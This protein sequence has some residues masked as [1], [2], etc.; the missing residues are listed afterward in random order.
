[1]MSVFPKIMKEQIIHMVRYR[2]PSGLAWV[3]GRHETVVVEA[4]DQHGEILVAD[5]YICG[6][7]LRCYLLLISHIC[8]IHPAECFQYWTWEKELIYRCL[9]LPVLHFL[10]FLLMA[11]RLIYIIYFEEDG[12]QIDHSVRQE[13]CWSIGLDLCLIGFWH[14]EGICLL[15]SCTKWRSLGFDDDAAIDLSWFIFPAFCYF[16]LCVVIFGLC[17][18]MCLLFHM[19]III[20]IWINY[21]EFCYTLW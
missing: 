1:M 20:I 18:L 12:M 11:W 17:V 8:A 4:G 3:Q 16:V 14:F 6:V 7:W 19:T 2:G 10:V 13:L 21:I 5:L 9:F 15:D